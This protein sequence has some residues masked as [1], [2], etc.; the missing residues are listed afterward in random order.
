[1]T[2]YTNYK[3]PTVRYSSDSSVGDG[4]LDT[5]PYEP[6]QTIDDTPKGLSHPRRDETKPN[7]PL[8]VVEP[9]ALPSLM[10]GLYRPRVLV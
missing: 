2:S 8:R 10:D 5:R 4:E 7:A 6:D 3:I 9:K 1:M